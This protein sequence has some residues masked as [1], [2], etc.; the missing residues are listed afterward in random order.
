M[1]AMQGS[2]RVGDGRAAEAACYGAG[3]GLP[4]A[5]AWHGHSVDLPPGFGQG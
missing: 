3:S 4:W 2:G 1:G 5:S